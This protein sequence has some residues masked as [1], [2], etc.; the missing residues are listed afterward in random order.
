MYKIK[1]KRLPKQLQGKVFNT[2]DEARQAVRKVLSA[3][4][5]SGR[6]SRAIVDVVNRTFTIGYYG[7][8]IVNVKR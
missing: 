2:Y 6:I 5:K 1:H 4:F 3:M 8:S 7:Y